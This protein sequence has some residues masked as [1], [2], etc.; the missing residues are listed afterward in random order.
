MA[1]RRLAKECQEIATDGSLEGISAGP[2]NDDLLK[3]QA[4]IMG[5]VEQI[6]SLSKRFDFVCFDKH[7]AR[8]TV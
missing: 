8:L 3:W 5:P 1:L 7:T 2:I 6:Y 4:A